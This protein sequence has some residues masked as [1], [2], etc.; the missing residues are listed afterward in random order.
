[1]ACGLLMIASIFKAMSWAGANILILISMI[2]LCTIFLPA[3]FVS[4]YKAGNRKKKAVY[5]TAFLTLFGIF[6]SALFKI[7]HWPTASYLLFVGMLLPVVLFMPVYLYSYNKEKDESI[8]NFLYIIFFLVCISGMG[9]LL[10]IRPV[11]TTLAD[12]IK[13]CHASDLSGFYP[14]QKESD[15]KSTNFSVIKIQKRATS[16][17]TTIKDMKT[18]LVIKSSENN[19]KALDS[20]NQILFWKIPNLEDQAVARTESYK[21]KMDHLIQEIGSFQDFLLT[22]QGIKANKF[23]GMMKVCNLIERIMFMILI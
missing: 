1:M 15:Q 8:Q 20:Q 18:E 3:A 12:A 21:N 17:L 14:F 16:L 5:I 10:A 7:M 19:R 23:T 4:C 11:R 22:L 13:I 9:T 2:V 6:V